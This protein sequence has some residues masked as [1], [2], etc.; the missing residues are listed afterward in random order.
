MAVPTPLFVEGGVLAVP[1]LGRHRVLQVD[2]TIE[3]G[4]DVSF[5][6]AFSARCALPVIRDS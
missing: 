1:P 6:F 2:R 5:N 3:P 4:Q